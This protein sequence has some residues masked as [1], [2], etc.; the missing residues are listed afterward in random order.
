MRRRSR[1]KLALPLGLLL[2]LAGCGAGYDVT[3]VSGTGSVKYCDVAPIVYRAL[4]Q[5][6][7]FKLVGI[8]GSLMVF[9][10]STEPKDVEVVV[11]WIVPDKKC[12]PV[13]HE[14][15]VKDFLTNMR[16]PFATLS[17]DKGKV[18]R[19]TLDDF[20]WTALVKSEQT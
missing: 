11:S 17:N 8:E 1:R 2:V 9:T 10:W 14:R 13:E 4:E 19:E 3:K 6:P 18:T 16:G 5:P 20:P 7:V 15:W 12:P